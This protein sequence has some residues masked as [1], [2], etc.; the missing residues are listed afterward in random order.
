MPFKELPCFHLAAIVTLKIFEIV[1]Q[2]KSQGF[3]VG[4][5]SE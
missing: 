5:I 4:N 3:P 2:I 1:L